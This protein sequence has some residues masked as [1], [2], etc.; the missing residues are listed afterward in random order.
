MRSIK[1][2]TEKI[3]H[4][5]KTKKV[6]NKNL[7]SRI[8]GNTGGRVGI[9]VQIK[10]MQWRDFPDGPVVET[11]RI[12]F[13]FFGFI[14]WFYLFAVI[15]VYLINLSFICIDFFLSPRVIC[16]LLFSYLLVWMIYSFSSNI[17][18]LL[19]AFKTA[20]YHRF[21]HTEFSWLSDL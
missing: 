9:C 2:N 18:F 11:A 5:I 8:S 13:F 21:W 12:I 15:I 7:A 14:D 20:I 10:K 19:N 17:Y 16:L 1:I 3:T 6:K 4:C